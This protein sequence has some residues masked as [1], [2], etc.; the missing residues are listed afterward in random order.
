MEDE[1]DE[2]I[3]EIQ[4]LAREEQLKS[5]ERWF[6]QRYEDPA[7]RTPYESAEGG[8]I[9]IWGGPYDPQEVLF[10][11]FG[12]RV[13]D[14]VIEELA[15]QLT[16][17]M[18][19][20]APVE[21]DEDY[22]QT[23]YDAISANKDALS[24]FRV[25][26]QTVRELLAES[27]SRPLAAIHP[28]LYANTITAIETYLSDTFINTVLKDMALL[29]RFIETTP[30]FKNRTVS[31]SNLLSEAEKAPEEAKRYL[32]D[33][34]WH[35]V[36]KVE[37]MYRDT[38]QIDFRSA[39]KDIARAVSVRHDIV[40]RN[41]RKKDGSKVSV[42]PTEVELLMADATLLIELIEEQYNSR[43]VPDDTDSLF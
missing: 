1:R 12:G 17:D 43:L 11:A 8:Y 32:L 33:M 26:I 24:T 7:N 9:Y 38:L 19:D 34:I 35:N 41:G 5:M 21:S 6:R 40:H 15:E 20:W 25:A 13:D 3:K 16:D 10:D 28:L 31:Y 22:D 29:R 4:E 39:I 37:N 18:P 23:F 36:A 42:G 27:V 30:E 2:N 14:E